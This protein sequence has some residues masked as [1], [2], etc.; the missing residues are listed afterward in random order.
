MS[1]KTDEMLS[2][3]SREVWSLEEALTDARDLFNEAI[4]QHIYNDGD[5]IPEDCAYH[6]MVKRIDKLID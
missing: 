4:S 3:V 5:D 6:A 2:A 1:L